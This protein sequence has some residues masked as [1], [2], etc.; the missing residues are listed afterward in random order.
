MESCNRIGKYNELKAAATSGCEV[1]RG[2][3]SRKVL[4]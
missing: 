1:M 3:C 2:V 4:Q